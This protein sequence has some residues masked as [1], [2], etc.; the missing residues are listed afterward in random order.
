MQ[1]QQQPAASD[2]LLRFDLHP[3]PALAVRK[4]TFAGG[5]ITIYTLLLCCLLIAL[6]PS[7]D[8]QEDLVVDALASQHAVDFFFDVVFSDVQDCTSIRVEA[9]DAIGRPLDRGQTL[10]HS[11]L[12]VSFRGCVVTGHIIVPPARGTFRFF[13]DGRMPPGSRAESARHMIRRLAVGASETLSG[14]PAVATRFQMADEAS[15]PGPC[16]WSYF[17]KLVPTTSHGVDGYQLAGTRHSQAMPP[18]HP[19][20]GSLVIQYESS[21]LRMKIATRSLSWPHAVTS[22]LGVIGGLVAVAALIGALA[23]TRRGK[24]PVL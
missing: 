19:Y 12:P 1:Q 9:L 11:R 15:C 13:V 17:I 14:V 8:L 24:A 20:V 18:A 2:F 6:K 21:P 10:R 23:A 3:K 7:Q 22:A 4:R 5:L 16:V